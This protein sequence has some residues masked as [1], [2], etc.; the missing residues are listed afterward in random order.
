MTFSGGLLFTCKWERIC[1]FGFLFSCIIS[2]TK[3]ELFFI[4]SALSKRTNS[5]AVIYLKTMS[6]GKFLLIQRYVLLSMPGKL[7]ALKGKPKCCSSLEGKDL[8]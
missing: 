1:V 3:T 5:D 4:Y 7:K 2:M 6:M 8:D